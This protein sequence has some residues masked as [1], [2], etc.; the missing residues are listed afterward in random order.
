MNRIMGRGEVRARRPRR[1]ALAWAPPAAGGPRGWREP[2]HAQ[3]PP[4]RLHD[5]GGPWQHD[6]VPSALQHCRRVSQT[7]VKGGRAPARGRT[8]RGACSETRRAARPQQ[9][10]PQST[11][12]KRGCA[13]PA[14][15]YRPPPPL[16]KRASAAATPGRAGSNACGA[17]SLA[18]ASQRP[19]RASSASARPTAGDSLKPWPLQAE[20]RMTWRG[21]GRAEGGAASPA[22]PRGRPGARAAATTAA[23]R[24]RRAPGADPPSRPRMRARARL[25][26]PRMGGDD[27]VAVGRV[28]KHADA[29]RQQ[30]ARGLGEELLGRRAQRRLV[31]GAAPLPRVGVGVDCLVALR[32]WVRGRV[33]AGSAAKGGVGGGRG[34]GERPRTRTSPTP[35]AG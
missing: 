8:V 34:H 6:L 4:A 26:V 33:G 18:N 11:P 30:R 3:S 27:E 35:A 19:C 14:P 20:Q 5:W 17:I 16:S 29:A 1:G 13:Q 22:A 7:P 25:G 24:A 31:N 9:A 23:P 15:P 10:R 28:G 12:D 21:R 32:G 2:G